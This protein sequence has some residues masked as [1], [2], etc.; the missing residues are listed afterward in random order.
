MVSVKTL[1]EALQKHPNP[2]AEICLHIWNSQ[3][4]TSKFER[5][6]IACTN[7]QAHRFV[8]IEGHG[9]VD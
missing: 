7:N 9:M 3:K 5:L 8:M 6:D 4:S 2:E 1:I